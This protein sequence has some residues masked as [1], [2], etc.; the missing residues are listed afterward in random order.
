MTARQSF[1]AL[2]PTVSEERCPWCDQAIPHEKFAEI[3]ARIEAK[4]RERTAEL[5]RRL[6][7][8]AALDKA[9]AEAKA[10]AEV[11]QAR[12]E[13]AAALER[14]RQEAAVKEAAVREEARKAA[15]TAMAPKLAEAEQ[16]RKAAEKLAKEQREALEKAKIE[17]VNAERAKA[18][19][20][21]LKLEEKL[22]QMQRQLQQK[23]AQELGE[24]AEVDLF[25]A[26]KAEFPADQI[27]RVDKGVAGA[28][29]VHKVMH[30]GKLCGCIVYD[31]K[32]RNQWRFEYVAKLRQD[33]ISEKA[34]HAI[35]S[36][37]VFPK[38][39][40]QLHLHDG[41]IIANPA[42]VIALAQV[43]RKHVIQSH[44][45]RQSNKARQEKTDL[46]Y[47]FVTSKRCSQLLDQIE[48]MT[49]DMLELEV[50]ETKAH[51]KTW[52]RRGELLRSVQRAHG[53]FIA[54]VEGIVGTAATKP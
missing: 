34:D 29:I 13:G 8:Q 16:G 47:E 11:E 7:E 45:F 21:R 20:E 46:L 42:R 25:E 37:H 18:F 10:K 51:E 32:N 39:A 33:Q 44:G 53:T 12:K 1:V 52:R 35:L 48:T 30:N 23:T 50:T 9:N 38:G 19:N 28:D 54:E 2:S 41:V 36:S 27:T 3:H 15:T 6:R 26:L 49:D 22:S 24:G 4:E 31:S 43:L 17:E 14:A 40:R 5:E